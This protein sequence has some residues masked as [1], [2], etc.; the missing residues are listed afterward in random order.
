MRY[1]N[2]IFVC[3]TTFTCLNFASPEEIKRQKESQNFIDKTPQNEKLDIEKIEKKMTAQHKQRLEL[4]RLQFC[5]E[6]QEH[7]MFLVST[8]AALK[9]GDDALK[10]DLLDSRVYNCQMSQTRTKI[11]NTPKKRKHGIRILSSNQSIHE[12]D[13]KRFID[14]EI[15]YAQSLKCPNF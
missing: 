13:L 14:E 5:Q 3:I 6:M 11:L 2:I 15:Q 4:E 8:L 7:I 12:A 9:A 10:K 1:K